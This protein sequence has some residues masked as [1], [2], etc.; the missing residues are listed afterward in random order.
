MNNNTESIYTLQFGLL[1]LSGLLFFSSFNMIIPELPSHLTRLGGGEYKGLIIALFTLTAGLS[2]PF[3]GK[4]ADRVGRVPVMI[5]GALVCGVAGLMYPLAGSVWA[6][7]LLRLFNGF[8][9]GFKPT[10]TSAY[11]ADI[12]PF[13]KRGEAMGVIGFFGTMGMALGPAVG[14]L[15]AE[16]FS[17]DIMFY[18][19]SFAAVLSVLILIGMKETLVHK[20]PV[21][22]EHFR[23]HR[24]EIYEPKVFAPAFMLML[25]VFA[26]GAILTV[27]PD[28]SDQLG[29]SRGLFFTYYTVASLLVRIVAGKASDKYGRVP[30]LKVGSFIIC[31]ALLCLANADSVFLL[32]FTAVLYGLGSGL[33]SPTV[34]A[35]TVDLSDVNR[36]GRGMATM[37]IFLEVGIGL[38]ALLSGWLY[39]NDLSN[40]SRVFYACAAMSA[41]GFLYLFSKSVRNL[42]VV[43]EV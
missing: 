7:L 17:L 41:V 25:S 28:V 1:C 24:D 19:S 4:L 3:S 31:I 16:H 40:I 39:A 20:E 9:T 10:G 22:W 21:R 30:V 27:L 26:F 33:C 32:L 6:F 38:G 29:M 35:W 13:S 15:I 18:C 2:R 11:V 8:S 14:P 34:F 23:I 5:V 12:I 42:P 43:T 36:R 37:Y